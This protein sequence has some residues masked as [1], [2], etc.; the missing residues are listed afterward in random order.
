MIWIRIFV[1]FRQIPRTPL[2]P[3]LSVCMGVLHAYMYITQSKDAV[4]SGM[5]TG[6][7]VNA[8]GKG[9][10]CYVNDDTNDGFNDYEA[11]SNSTHST[12]FGKPPLP[13]SQWNGKP[14]PAGWL[15]HP[16]AFL[17]EKP[18]LHHR[19]RRMVWWQLFQQQQ[20]E[21]AE[22]A[23]QTW[24]QSTNA[25][26]PHRQTDCSADNSAAAAVASDVLRRDAGR[27]GTRNW[28]ARLHRIVVPVMSLACSSAGRSTC[29]ARRPAEK[30]LRKRQRPVFPPDFFGV[31]DARGFPVFPRWNWFWRMM[32]SLPTVSF[33]LITFFLESTDG[34]TCYIREDIWNIWL[35]DCKC[36]GWLI[37]WWCLLF[38][39]NS[40]RSVVSLHTVR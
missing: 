26:P 18:L 31:D 13:S 39:G 30:N 20:L 4:P 25:I 37:Q 9:P 19:S 24:R 10:L 2:I 32:F 35:F 15:S 29:D 14:S 34:T 3:Q 1:D 36:K 40:W 5:G 22:N 16:T 28:R 27:H 8:N 6:T 12:R 11:T 33:R 38:D 17:P 7:N 21:T 23:T